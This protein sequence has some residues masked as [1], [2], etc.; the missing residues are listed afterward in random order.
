MNSMT[1]GGTGNEKGNPNESYA[2]LLNMMKEQGG[3]SNNPPL[4]LAVMT[5]PNA[6]KIGD[7][8]LTSQDLLFNE[9]LLHSSCIGVKEIAPDGGGTCEDNSSYLSALKA[10][11]TV[12]VQ[13]MSDTLYC[14][15]GKMV[16]G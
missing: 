9:A 11:D 16:K 5:G 14:V 8:Q 15:L 3:K 12:L 4:Q 1:T 2:S 13:R 7:L 6:C 10:G